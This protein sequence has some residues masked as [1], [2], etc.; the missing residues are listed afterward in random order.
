MAA[1]GIAALIS[2]RLYDRVGLWSLSIALALAVVAATLIFSNDPARVWIGAIVW[3]ATAGIHESTM[4]AA[5]AAIVPRSRRGEGYLRRGLRPCLAGGIDADRAALPNID[6]RSRRVRRGNAAR[7]NGSAGQTRSTGLI[8][9]ASVFGNGPP[10]AASRRCA[11]IFVLC[12][13]GR[14]SNLSLRSSAPPSTGA[15]TSS[16]SSQSGSA[17]S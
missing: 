15:L 7:G 2:G 17:A 9:A 11:T 4:R 16:L 8:T 1:A 3:G 5:V 10:E 6:H 13:G 12:Y 14:A